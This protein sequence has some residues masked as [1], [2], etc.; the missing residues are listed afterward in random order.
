MK[1]KKMLFALL[2]CSSGAVFANSACD[3][4]KNDFDGLYCLNKVYQEADKE[5]ND[6]YK[7]LSSKLDSAGK[8]ALKSGQLSWIQD[9]N[10]NCSKREATEFFVNLDCA[11][12]KTISRSQFL[13]DRIREC[14]SSGCQN[15]K[16]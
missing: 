11:T 15:S 12:S 9:R 6:N 5:L 16:L 10:N 13:Q 3:A 1:M 4:P 8:K 7:T 2:F 14:S